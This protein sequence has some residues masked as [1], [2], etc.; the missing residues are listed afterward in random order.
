MGLIQADAQTPYK[1]LTTCKHFASIVSFLAT[2]K[3]PHLPFLG[4]IQP[5]TQGSD[6]IYLKL[7]CSSNHTQTS[8]DSRVFRSNSMQTQGRSMLVWDWSHSV[9]IQFSLMQAGS[10][11]S[12]YHDH[13]FCLTEMAFTTCFNMYC[14]FGRIKLS[15]LDQ[16]NTFCKLI[17]ENN[18]C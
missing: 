1:D 6:E 11:N 15:S 4:S 10:Q 18:T 13:V 2:M 16:N 17:L 9:L 12:L 5:F 3:M 7:D 8:T 14:P